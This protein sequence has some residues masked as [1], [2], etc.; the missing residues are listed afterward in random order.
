M[1]SSSSL[2]KGGVKSYLS[3]QYD[4]VLDSLLVM[5]ES[6]SGLQP[7]SSSTKAAGP[8]SSKDI[9]HMVAGSLVNASIEKIRPER[10]DLLENNDLTLADTNASD[11]LIDGLDGKTASVK[12]LP[13]ETKDHFLEI[14]LDRLIT[15][16]TPTYLPEREHFHEIAKPR[17]PP[18]SAAV[19]AGNFKKLGGKM[20]SLL[21]FRDSFI[22]LLTWRNPSGTI[23]MLILFTLI[24]YN[25]MYLILLPLFEVMY[26]TIIAAYSFRHPLKR[27]V[28]PTRK[29]Y[30]RSLLYEIFNGGPSTAIPIPTSENQHVASIANEDHDAEI[31]HNPNEDLS[32]SAKVIV[33]LRDLQDM[34]TGLVE[35]NDSITHFNTEVTGFRDEY[36]STKVFLKFG[37]LFLTLKLISP[38]INWSFVISAL[39]WVTLIL[40]HPKL[41]KILENSKENPESDVEE[42]TLSSEKNYD[43]VLDEKPEIR[44]VELFEIYQQGIIPR[45]WRFLKFSN[46]VFD[47]SDPYRKAQQPPPGVLQLDE[48]LPPKNWEFDKNYPWEVDH[49]VASWAAEKG[50]EMEIEGEFLYDSLFKRRRLTRKVLKY[51]NPTLNS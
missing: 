17:E 13:S 26:G 24:C 32:G 19:L 35:L 21:E 29:K 5:E 49:H 16:L 14:F 25:P 36:R 7:P 3:K 41:R 34:T 48:V 18:V 38:Y 28:Y 50:L 6:L 31:L 9:F 22:R 45:Y 43:I 51:A 1:S 27:D 47:T 15:R 12:E 4:R 39:A 10:E 46:T 33:N 44:T 11:E 30:G 23:T 40:M 37:L 2:K 42:P 20:D 8:M